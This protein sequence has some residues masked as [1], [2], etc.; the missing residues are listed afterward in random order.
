MESNDVLVKGGE[1]KLGIDE[2]PKPFQINKVATIVRHPGYNPE[3]K[4]NDVALLILTEKFRSDK[5][6]DTLCLPEPNED[7][8]KTFQKAKCITT[9]W[10][11]TTLQCKY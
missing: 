6:V 9:G 8:G 11:K 5:N 3:T 4:L 10:G 2:E 1:W 7:V